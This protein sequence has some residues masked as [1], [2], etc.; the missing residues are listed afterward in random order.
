MSLVSALSHLP[1]ELRVQIYF[2]LTTNQTLTWV[3]RPSFD[4]FSSPLA[5]PAL[6]T[7]HNS[8]IPTEQLDLGCTHDEYE[9]YHRST[10]LSATIRAGTYDNPYAQPYDQADI[11]TPTWRALKSRQMPAAVKNYFHPVDRITFFIDCGWE[12]RTSR[13]YRQPGERHWRALQHF[14]RC[15]TGDVA[16]FRS[17]RVAMYWSTWRFTDTETST[18]CPE[19]LSPGAFLDAQ[20]ASFAGLP[21][22]HRGE[23]Y[24]L[25]TSASGG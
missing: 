7:L 1:R 16:R 23:A 2:H 10:R 4:I 17:F 15:T 21:I 14:E 12:T 20:P 6:I 24:W 19:F 5:S 18:T 3:G 9:Q 22:V 11:S 8:P 13:S 25:Y